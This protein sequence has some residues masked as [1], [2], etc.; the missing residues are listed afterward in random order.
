MA[1]DEASFRA[2]MTE[3]Q[4]TSEDVA[5]QMAERLVALGG[6]AAAS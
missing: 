3:S 6:S 2:L 5:R 4:Q 1:L